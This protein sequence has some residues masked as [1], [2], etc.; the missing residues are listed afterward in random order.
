MVTLYKQG[1]SILGIAD[2]LR[3]SRS[4]VRNFVSAG[5]FPERATALRT[6]SLLDPYTP[7]LISPSN[8]L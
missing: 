3:M 6:K 8:I 4:T 2:Q 7:Y 5:A 1:M